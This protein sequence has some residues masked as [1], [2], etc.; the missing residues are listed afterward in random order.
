[1]RV[2]L[3]LLLEGIGFKEELSLSGESFQTVSTTFIC[4][5]VDIGLLQKCV[6]YHSLV[7]SQGTSHTHILKRIK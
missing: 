4:S 6:K 5:L 1:M 7:F 3:G 2:G